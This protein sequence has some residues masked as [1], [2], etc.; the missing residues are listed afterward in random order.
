MSKVIPVALQAHYEQVTT[1]VT[2]CLH[3]TRTDGVTL[4]VTAFNR[5]LTIDCTAAGLGAAEL[6]EGFGFLRNDI[7]YDDNMG[8]GS[9]EVTGLLNSAAIT[10]ADVVAGRWD[11]FRYVLFRVNW[12]SVSDGIDIVSVGRVGVVSTGRLRVIAELLSLLQGVQNGIGMLNS[13]LCIHELGDFNAVPERGNGCTVVVVP[14]TGSLT[15]IDSDFYGMHDTARV[16]VDS[17][18]SNGVMTLTSGPFSGR[19]IEVRAYVVG[20][21]ILFDALPDTVTVGT[22]YEMTRGCNKTRRQCIDDFG[23]ILDRLASDY[24]QGSDAAVQV[25]RHSG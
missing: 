15:G 14:V 21:W 7:T 8:V 10:E 4:G 9:T 25:A 24:T 19:R 12:A 16:E 5:A 23:K 6:F 3:A 17:Y 2:M 1:T 18:F 13:D 22:T 11:D 20:F